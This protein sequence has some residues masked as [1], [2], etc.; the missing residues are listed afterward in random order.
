MDGNQEATH[1]GT[2]VFGTSNGISPEFIA[3]LAATSGAVV[4]GTATVAEDR[5]PADKSERNA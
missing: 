4:A 1:L 3:E 2:E 5:Q